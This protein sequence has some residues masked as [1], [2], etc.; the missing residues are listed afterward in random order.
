MKIGTSLSEFDKWNGGKQ[1]VTVYLVMKVDSRMYADV[2]VLDVPEDFNISAYKKAALK[3]DWLVN[4]LFCTIKKKT[5]HS[6]MLPTAPD[7]LKKSIATIDKSIDDLIK[8][9]QTI[10]GADDD[11]PYMDKLQELTG[12]NIPKWGDDNPRE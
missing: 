6:S 7:F 11:K 4:K 1:K 8:A 5:F 10:Y 3:I 12:F 2:C 9:N